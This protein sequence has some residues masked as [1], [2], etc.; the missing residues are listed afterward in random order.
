MSLQD[1]ESA[2]KEGDAARR[3]LR[4]F[5]DAQAQALRAQSAVFNQTLEDA[6]TVAAQVLPASPAQLPLL[7][8]LAVFARPLPQHQLSLTQNSS[9]A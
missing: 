5:K 1:L 4:D 6:K 8:C 9:F 7:S 3:S 2:Y